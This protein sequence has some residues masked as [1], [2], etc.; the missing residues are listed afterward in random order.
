MKKHNYILIILLLNFLHLE[1]LASEKI[2]SSVPSDWIDTS[3]GDEAT[4]ENHAYRYEPDWLTN[5]KMAEEYTQKMAIEAAIENIEPNFKRVMELINDRFSKWFDKKNIIK[6]KDA[7]RCLI[8]Y[9]QIFDDLSNVAYVIALNAPRNAPNHVFF[10]HIT[11]AVR[12]YRPKT[13]L[14]IAN[15]TVWEKIYNYHGDDPDLQKQSRLLYSVLVWHAYFKIVWE[16]TAENAPFTI[17]S[18]PQ[19]IK[20]TA[21]I[22][23]RISERLVFIYLYVHLEEILDETYLF[24]HK[25]LN[26]SKSEIIDMIGEL[27][28]KTGATASL[29]TPYSKVLRN[30]VENLSTIRFFKLW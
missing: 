26:L 5:S 10:K 7:K 4:A 2:C 29:L 27:P 11:D 19:D 24:Q 8:S 28:S 30:K 22:A 25:I 1:V 12:S 23:Y 18:D 6:L 13:A 15:E 14:Y 16:A 21:R 3:D 17:L 20:R 9:S